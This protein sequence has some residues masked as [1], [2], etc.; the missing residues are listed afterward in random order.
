M[1]LTLAAL[2]IWG[3]LYVMLLGWG[4]GDR[5]H[6]LPILVGL[7][8]ICRGPGAVDRFSCRP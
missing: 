2:L 5:E 4:P 3:A 8:A 7:S 1:T 6:S